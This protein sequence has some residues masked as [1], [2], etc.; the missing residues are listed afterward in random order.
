MG[1]KE[2]CDFGEMRGCQRH[3]IAGERL[4]RKKFDKNVRFAFHKFTKVRIEI[5]FKITTQIQSDDL[6]NSNYPPTLK[7]ISFSASF[8]A[9]YSPHLPHWRPASA[10]DPV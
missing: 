2:R 3:I 10:F 6:Q 5:T 9:V 8:P 1:G 4:S 7:L